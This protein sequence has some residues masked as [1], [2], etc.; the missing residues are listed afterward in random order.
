MNAPLPE[1]VGQVVVVAMFLVAAVGATR[2]L[3]TSRRQQRDHHPSSHVTNIRLAP[4]D[5]AAEDRHPLTL[6][7]GSVVAPQAAPGA[8]R[9]GAA[10]L[11]QP[12]ETAR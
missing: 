12:G 8:A 4:Y 2:Q 7:K 11:Q 6:P 1:I 5:W 10:R 9:G 3:L